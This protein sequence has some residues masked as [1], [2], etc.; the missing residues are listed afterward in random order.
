MFSKKC[1]KGEIRDGKAVVHFADLKSGKEEEVE[2]KVCLIST[3]RKPYTKNL[4]LENVGIEVDKL[5][6]IPINDSF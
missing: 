5:G 6:R 3:G 2:S 4:G 1:I